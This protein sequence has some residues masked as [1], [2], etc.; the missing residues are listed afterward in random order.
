MREI[1]LAKSAGFCFGVQ[2]AV[3]TA[4]TNNNSK[5][6]IYTLGPLIHN[7][8]V[9]N[10]LEEEN[11]FS[12]NLDDAGNLKE[13]ETIIIRS[14]GI[15][16][17]TFKLLESKNLHII[18][19]TC[20][21][22]TNIHKKVEKY[23]NL[24]YGI[25]IVGD[26][27]HPEVIGINGWC[28][29]TGIITKDGSELIEKNDL[30]ENVCLVSQTTEKQ[31]NFQKVLAV[32]KSKCNEVI[33]FN[34]IC[35]ATETRQKSADELS[36]EV[37]V[38]IVIGGKHSSN[39][40]KLYEICKN[41]CENTFLV[42]NSREIPDNII[43]SK[44]YNKIGITAGASTPDWVIKEA[45]EKMSNNEELTMHDVMQ[46]MDEN[47]VQIKVGDKIKGK[48]VSRNE[49]GIYLNINYKA[50]AF[51][52]KTEILGDEESLKENDE[53][54]VKVISRKN[55][56]GYVVVSTLELERE[57]ISKEL[58]EAF[59]N[60][61]TIKV[62]IIEVVK[63]GVIALY[64]DVAKLFL[65]ASQI[66]LFHVDDLSTY[67]G[68]VIEV[69]IIEYEKRRG[70]SKIVVS[71]RQLL[72]KAKDLKEEEVFSKLQK[73]S[74]VEGEV[75][76]ISS[77]GAFVEID[78]IDGLLHISEISWGKI[79]HPSDVL[80][81]GDKIE[82]AV[83]DIDKDS[84]KL[85]L[86]M[87]QTLENPWNNV[88]DKYP[89][90]NIVLGKVVRFVNF[91]AFVEL[92][93]GVDGLVHISQIS[94]KRISKADETLTIGQEVKAKILLVDPSKKRIELSLKEV[95]FMI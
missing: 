14:H 88:E 92:E 34:T 17:D 69:A 24:G 85:S 29:N 10:K 62:K 72:K 81:I 45:I 2:R 16:K 93:P 33:A 53:V 18:D 86:S 44:K 50:D 25:I 43:N 57:K 32:V 23:Y 38:M 64:K 40:N 35:S 39:T 95:D 83:I 55:E 13:N 7:N 49:N 78:G 54:D 48:V 9:V 75:K 27:D 47:D 6:K 73:G 3:E 30:S 94:E 61:Q 65:P 91:G 67:I 28:N 59:D 37:D 60:A 74:I 70:L 84:K 1:F 87:K 11:V 76:R 66:E 42:E 51:L 68:K 90:G 20:P 79:N 22:V 15:P 56:E 89:V 31:S 71:R 82:V 77:F 12:I 5:K 26:K 19:A 46:F 36:K 41:N 4:L 80:K 21:Y 8:D 52:P 58:K 63:G